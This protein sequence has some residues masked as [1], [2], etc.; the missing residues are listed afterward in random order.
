VSNDVGFVLLTHS[1]PEQTLR[2]VRTLQRVYDNPPICIHHDLSKSKIHVADFPNDVRFV[3]PHIKTKWAR[4]PVV[5]ATLKAL[6]NLYDNANPKWFF[7]LSGAC[8]P[9]MPAE[10]VIRDLSKSGVDALLDYREVGNVEPPGNPALAYYVAPGNA[11][12]VHGWYVGLHLWAPVVRKGPTLGKRSFFFKMKDWRAPFDSTFKC[13][14]GDHWFAGNQR[15]ASVLLKPSHKHLQLRRHLR[16]RPVP[17]ECYY[18]CV[19]AN[20]DIKISKDTRR[21]VDWRGGMHPQLLGVG[22]LD[23]IKQSKAYFARKFA[24]NDPALDEI[25]R[26]I[27]SP[28]SARL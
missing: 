24:P 21:F 1:N 2:L 3:T 25:D 26:M 14:Y 4:F 23:A 22:H 13:F 15:A 16:M 11:P 9:V 18:Q 6:Q 10:V 28:S 12:L 19:L 8:Y 5:T 7:L 17:E 27:L 20:S